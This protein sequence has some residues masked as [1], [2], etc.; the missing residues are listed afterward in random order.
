MEEIGTMYILH[1]NSRESSKWISPPPE[2]L[3]TPERL[4]RA[5][6]SGNGVDLEQSG[7]ARARAKEINGK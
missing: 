7:S 5:V 2:E 6:T 1:V 4:A 3:V